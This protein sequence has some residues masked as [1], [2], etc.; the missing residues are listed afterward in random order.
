LVEQLSPKKDP[1][2]HRVSINQ[3]SHKKNKILQDQLFKQL[4]AYAYL[5]NANQ[6]KYDLTLIGLNTQQT[7]GNEQYPKTIT[8]TNSVLS[9][10]KFNTMTSRNQNQNQNE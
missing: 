2:I 9:N 6:S 7:L 1:Q 10:H 4:L 8:D 3:I 5:D